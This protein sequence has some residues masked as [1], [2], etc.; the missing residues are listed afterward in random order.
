LQAI[1]ID[2]VGGLQDAVT[3]AN[4]DSTEKNEMVKSATRQWRQR[5][6]VTQTSRA[7][8]KARE[9][10]LARGAKAAMGDAGG[11]SSWGRE[12]LRIAGKQLALEV[13]ARSG[14]LG[15]VPWGA[16]KIVDSMVSLGAIRMISMSRGVTKA[17]ATAIYKK[18]DPAAKR[19]I[20]QAV[21]NEG[22]AAGGPGL[23][24]MFNKW[25]EQAKVGLSE[26]GESRVAQLRSSAETQ[27]KLLE[28]KLDMTRNFGV[29][30]ADFWGKSGVEEFREEVINKAGKGGFAHSELEVAAMAT[31]GSKENDTAERRAEIKKLWLAQNK[32][33]RPEE[34]DTWYDSMRE[35][36]QGLSGA[37]RERLTGMFGEGGTVGQIMKLVGT[38]RAIK[39]KEQF[40]AGTEHLQQFGFDINAVLNKGGRGGVQSYADLDVEHIV[41]GID[42]G[43]LKQMRGKGGAYARE[44]ELIEKAKRGDKKAAAALQRTWATAGQ[45]SGK[46]VSSATG[47]GGAEAERLDRSEGAVADMQQTFADFAPAVKDFQTGAK[48]L[49]DAMESE[50]LSRNKG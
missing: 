50:W 36:A 18:M 32:G 45:V 28:S 42:E 44:A 10:V 4:L 34:F 2:A 19:E 23:A 8:G 27:V 46:K 29:V 9:A 5:L 49:R 26:A 39:G 25:E 12:A 24:E 33:K 3:A 7:T 47:A 21:V 30:G 40:L 37:A 17:E 14:I 31:A 22:R 35:R 11:S 38:S 13:D 6:A 16:D 20:E 41:G 15:I 1:G 43:A 48:M